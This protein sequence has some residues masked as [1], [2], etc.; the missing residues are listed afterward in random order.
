MFNAPTYKDTPARSLESFIACIRQ[1]R[2]PGDSLAARLDDIDPKSVKDKNIRVLLRMWQGRNRD[3][4]ILS[5]LMDQLH[6][7]YQ[8]L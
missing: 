2:A 4:R 5:D 3:P 8:T 1:N 6:G 7:T